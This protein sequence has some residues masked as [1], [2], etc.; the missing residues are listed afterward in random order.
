MEETGFWADKAILVLSLVALIAFATA[1]MIMATVPVTATVN[2]QA[3]VIGLIRICTGGSCSLAQTGKANYTH[4]TVEVTV[5]DPNGQSDINTESFRIVL[6]HGGTDTNNS[7]EDWDV[8]AMT[9][10]DDNVSLFSHESCSQTAP[11]TGSVYCI[12]I[13]KTAWTVKFLNGDVNIYVIVDDN[14]GLFDENA[15]DKNAFTIAKTTGRS[16]DNTSGTYSGNAN[17]A[18]NA[19]TGSPNANPYIE[20]TH[21]G[22]NHIDVTTRGNDLNIDVQP[23]DPATWFIGDG[24]QSW[25]LDQDDGAGSTPFTGLAAAVHSDWNRGI[26]PD[27]SPM[28]LYL[29]LDIPDQQRPGDYNGTL[30]YGSGAS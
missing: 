24:N 6:F 5:T 1:P 30:I 4:F 8:N 15:L 22:N 26:Y 29:Y 12:N 11:I 18:N 21:N 25:E 23:P 28:R 16:E 9:I 14:S 3:P 20:S 7:S 17:T 10:L 2:N 27:S 19:F 13:P